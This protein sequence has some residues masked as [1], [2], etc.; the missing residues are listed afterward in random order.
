VPP[1]PSGVVITSA[2]T[3]ITPASTS[4][5]GASPPPT[6]GPRAPGAPPGGAEPPRRRR[7][8]HPWRSP[9][10]RWRVLS[11]KRPPSCQRRRPQRGEARPIQRIYVRSV[12]AG[13]FTS[14]RGER[15]LSIVSGGIHSY[16]SPPSHEWAFDDETDPTSGTTRALSRGVDVLNQKEPSARPPIRRS[17]RHDVLKEGNRRILAGKLGSRD[18]SKHEPD[19]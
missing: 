14:L 12:A 8:R 16:K 1:P 17:S 10:A 5:F 18:V 11:V 7:D 15:W 13:W 6:V 19:L 3:S 9:R 2:S 4:A